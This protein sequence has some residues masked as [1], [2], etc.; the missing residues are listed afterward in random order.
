MRGNYKLK[1]KYIIGLALAGML[2]GCT[3]SA[4]TEA[5][6]QGKLAMAGREYTEALNLFQLAIEEGSTDEEILVMIEILEVYNEAK[7]KFDN[8][9]V[10]EALELINQ[11]RE[12]YV[13][14]SIKNDV[15]NLISEIN[16]S[17]EQE[18]IAENIEII[19][20]LVSEKK[21]DEALESINSLLEEE[22]S[23]SAKK[24]LEEIKTNINTRK[25]VITDIAKIKELMSNKSYEEAKT[26]I[27]S[28]QAK[29]LNDEE[30]KEVTELKTTVEEELS[31]P[32]IITVEEAR[33]HLFTYFGANRNET[34]YAPNQNNSYVSE[35]W[36]KDEYYIF[37]IEDLWEGEVMMVMDSNILV[38]KETK[39]VASYDLSTGLVKH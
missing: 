4:M 23:E 25:E 16:T 14:Y 8:A 12:D 15:D 18:K 26:L 19:N 32:K 28:V 6:S 38:H 20:S 31:K 7:I 17:I 10:E 34:N 2:A 24:E 39:A 3:D 1:R 27:E 36:I 33:E 37:N 29:S 9:N 13:D 21:Y 11:I 22:I 35:Q 5:I 30:S